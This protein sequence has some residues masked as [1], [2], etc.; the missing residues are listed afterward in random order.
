MTK[1]IKK[2]FFEK[3]RIKKKVRRRGRKGDMC[4]VLCHRL[5][6]PPPPPIPLRHSGFVDCFASMG[7]PI[8]LLLYR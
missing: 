7:V 4:P 1:M 5:L 2:H 6:P 3:I 8:T